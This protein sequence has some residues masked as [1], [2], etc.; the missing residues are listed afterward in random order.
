MKKLFYSL[1]LL[2]IGITLNLQAQVVIGDAVAPQPFSALEII[3]NGTGGLRLPQLNNA[4]RTAVQTAIEALAPAEQYKAEGLMIFNID[5]GCVEFWNGTEWISNCVG[6]DLGSIGSLDCSGA[7][8]TVLSGAAVNVTKTLT[9]SDLIG[10]VSVTDGQ[11]LGTEGS[12]TVIANG[13]QDLTDPSGTINIK[14]TG[15]APAVN[16]TIPVELAGADCSISVTISTPEA[17][18]AGA[19]SF[20]GRTCFDLALSNNNTT[21]G[22]LAGRIAQQANFNLTATNTQTYT[23]IPT[24]TVSDIRFYFVET[25]GTGLIVT[26]LTANG[27]YSGN[28]TAGNA[29]TATLVYKSGLNTSALGRT[30][31]NALT[32]DIYVIYNNAANGSGD[33]RS[34]KLTVSIKDCICC[35][36]PIKAEDGGGWLTLMCHNLGA[37][38]SL[39]PFTWN[40]SKGANDGSDIKGDLYQWGRKP[41]AHAKR[42]S[43]VVV[44]P[45]NSPPDNMFVGETYTMT[46]WRVTPNH[47][48]WGDGSDNRNIPKTAN[49]P[50]PA[51]WKVPSH[52]QL[53]SIYTTIESGANSTVHTDGTMTW[54]WTGNGFKVGSSLYLPAAGIRAY[55]IGS[56]VFDSGDRGSYWTSAVNTTYGPDSYFLG[57]G[58]GNVYL[59]SICRQYGYSV[60]CTLE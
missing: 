20:S 12:L 47:T 33:D 17:I 32:V 4:Q 35:G 38:E 5:A 14:I 53:A 37:N 56:L 51:G 57:F 10:I 58:S 55:G 7:A 49:D 59:T 54:K 21:C 48:L 15:T 31:T 18:T 2:F 46:D 36:A 43:A 52:K 22:T 19:G 6:S 23:F 8:I 30:A 3:S 34:A 1:L 16:T 28:A 41:A 44:G 24:G 9:Y 25:N 40:N 11:E 27:D 50:C 26:S 13:D 45:T 60:R 42:N 29:Y 39:D